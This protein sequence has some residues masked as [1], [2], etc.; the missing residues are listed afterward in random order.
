MGSNLQVTNF[1]ETEPFS[2]L[3][4]TDLISLSIQT[5]LKVKLI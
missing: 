4:Y 3:V 5:S 1:L 2:D